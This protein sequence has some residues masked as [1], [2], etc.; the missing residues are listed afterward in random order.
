MLRRRP[1]CHHCLKEGTEY[2]RNL[3][4]PLLTQNSWCSLAAK[5]EKHSSKNKSYEVRPVLR[6]PNHQHFYLSD[7]PDCLGTTGFSV[8]TLPSSKLSWCKNF[9]K[10]GKSKKQIFSNSVKLLEKI[11]GL[12][13]LPFSLCYLI[14]SEQKT[15]TPGGVWKKLKGWINSDLNTHKRELFLLQGDFSEWQALQQHRDLFEICACAHSPLQYIH[16]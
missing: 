15:L 8:R 2:S 3:R 6:S 1:G 11:V 9:L 16:L 14:I 10:T 4:L 13:I 12:L 5:Q 7:I